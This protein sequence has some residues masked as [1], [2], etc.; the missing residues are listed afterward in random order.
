MSTPFITAMER[1]R[2]RSRVRK[3]ER[4]K[5]RQ[6]HEEENTTAE[7]SADAI[8]HQ[9]RSECQNGL[10]NIY[11]REMAESAGKNDVFLRWNDWGWTFAQDL[12]FHFMHSSNVFIDTTFLHSDAH[13]SII[14]AQCD[15]FY[16][17]HLNEILVT[18]AIV[19]HAEKKEKMHGMQLS[20]TVKHTMLLLLIN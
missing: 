16:F 7:H 3:E 2:E 13:W 17:L 10:L 12:L 15:I 8:D 14:I 11:R 9:I 20:T 5:E 6:V 18:L 4:E 1:E 19:L